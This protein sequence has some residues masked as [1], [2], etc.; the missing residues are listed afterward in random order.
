MS[1]LHL[2]PE[3]LRQI[4]DE[5]GSS[6]FHEDLGRLTIC[7]WWCDFAVPVSLKRITVVPITLRTLVVSEA[8]KTPNKPKLKD[9]LEDLNVELGGRLRDVSTPSPEYLSEAAAFEET[10]NEENTENPIMGLIN[11]LSKLA[12]MAQQSRKLRVLRIRVRRLL[13]PDVDAVNPSVNYLLSST[14]KAFLSLQNLDA[15]VL[16]SF[17]GFP[18]PPGKQG[19]GGHICSVIRTLLPTLRTLHLRMRH[20][21]PDVLKPRDSDNRLR[22]EVVVV[23]LSLVS[24]VTAAM[25][26]KRCGSRVGVLQLQA[27]MKEQAEAIASRMASR[28]IVRIISITI[29]KLEVQ[30]FDVLTGKTMIMEEDMGWDEDGKTVVEESEPESESEISSLS[31]F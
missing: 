4:F 1:L 17:V 31:D 25:H 14:I 12:N 7:K 30:S 22:L 24:D 28:K 8:A 27:D 16:D 3:L 11:D 29:P 18:S 9:S 21:C 23:N 2:P 15:L 10:V 19:E 20:I 6:F 5:V 13:P 26:S